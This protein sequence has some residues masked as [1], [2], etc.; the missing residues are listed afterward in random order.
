MAKFSEK[1]IINIIEYRYHMKICFMVCLTILIL[2]YIGQCFFLKKWT[3][4]TYFDLKKR[5]GFRNGGSM[6]KEDNM[7]LPQCSLAALKENRK[8]G[9]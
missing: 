9:E 6:W 3:Y 2:N 5:F 1:T 4:F 8:G 7:F